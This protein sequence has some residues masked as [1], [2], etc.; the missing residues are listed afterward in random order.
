MRFRLLLSLLRV[1]KV[2]AV[3]MFLPLDRNG[4]VVGGLALIVL[5]A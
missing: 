1:A 2:V 5:P 3:S 4:V